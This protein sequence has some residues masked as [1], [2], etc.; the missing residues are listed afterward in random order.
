MLIFDN[1]VTA[2]LAYAGQG[3]PVVPLYPI[4]LN[5]APDADGP[6]KGLYP[7]TCG[8]KPGA[9]CSPGKHPRTE[10]GLT[11]ATTDVKIIAGWAE[12]WPVSNLAIITGAAS[13][14]VV[15][16]V[17]PKHGGLQSIRDL[18]GTDIPGPS[19]GALLIQ[20]TGSSGY[21]LLFRHPDKTVRN[22]VGLRPGLDVRGDGGYIVVSPSNHESG[23]HYEWLT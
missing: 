10:H 1:W 21:H 19:W 3:W 7:C 8:R 22:R 18:T 23:G 16:D 11:D 20:R 12:K 5:A 17:D 15:L 2:A 13:G 14:V 9:D 4:D 6:R